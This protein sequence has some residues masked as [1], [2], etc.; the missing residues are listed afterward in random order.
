MDP[1]DAAELK[2]LLVG[3][4]L[5]AQKS[6][7]LEYAVQQHAEPALLG[8]LRSLSDE[9]SYDSLDAVV[10]DLLQVKAGQP[11]A[12]PQEPH[13]EG[14]QPPGGDSYTD[15]HPEPGAVRE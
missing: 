1:A 3:V 5:P 9:T 15:P 4:A 11:P 8:A 13:E 10:E 6:E 14:G 7:L 12:V 2:T